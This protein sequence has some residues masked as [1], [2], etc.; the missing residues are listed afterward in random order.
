ML[1]QKKVK[2]KKIR[3]YIIKFYF[4]VALPISWLV[5]SLQL[6]QFSY[7]LFF[8]ITYI[9]NNWFSYYFVTFQYFIKTVK[10]SPNWFD[11][12][13][14]YGKLRNINAYSL[15]IRGSWVLYFHK[16]NLNV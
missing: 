1:T 3:D 6:S 11:S 4:E 7:K 12:F 16:F 8:S 13:D 14:S 2:N 5:L 9:Y 15:A 10:T